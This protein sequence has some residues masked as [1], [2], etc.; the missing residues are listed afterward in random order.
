[1]PHWFIRKPDPIPD[2]ARGLFEAYPM[3]NGQ[4]EIDLKSTEFGRRL[5]T[6][7]P[8]ENARWVM[9][10]LEFLLGVEGRGKG[11]QLR[12]DSD[13]GPKWHQI[14]AL[15]KAISSLLRRKLPFSG[16]DLTI[17][18]FWVTERHWD[19][20][21]SAVIKAVERFAEA[22]TLP[23]ALTTEL[24][25]L[26]DTL[27]PDRKLQERVLRLLGHGPPLPI[28]RGDVWADAALDYL[29]AQDRG[30][31]A[32]W[33]DL[34]LH[35][36][37]ANAGKPSKRWQKQADGL[38]EGIGRGL[39]ST[40]LREWLPL[41]DVPRQL[42]PDEK[43]SSYLPDSHLS[44]LEAQGADVLKGLI[45]CTA[46]WDDSDITRT[47]SSAAISAYKKIPGI[48]PRA[49]KVG[50]A[51]VW[52]LGQMPGEAPLGALAVLKLRIKL[53]SVQN[54]I[55][56]ALDGAAE[57][58]GIQR[59]D[60]E[61][62]IVPV[63]GLQEVGLRREPMGDFVAELTVVSS[64]RTELRWR[65]LDGTLQKSIPKAVK[66]AHGD[67]LKELKQTAKDIEKML[68]AQGARIDGLFLTQKRWTYGVWRQRYLDHPLV[69]T[70]ARRLIWW[71]G[72]TDHRESVCWQD[73]ALCDRQ[74]QPVAIPDEDTECIAL[75]HPIEDSVDAV[76]S[77]RR[78]LS[79]L[80]I[81]QPFK[82]AHREIYLLTDAEKTTGVYSNRFASHILKQHSFNA[83]CGA[84]GWKN[85]LRL[86]V[87]ADYNPARRHLPVWDLR[88]EFW[89]DG[90]RGAS[91]HDINDV[92][93]YLYLT[94]DQVR[95]YPLG[96]AGNKAHAMGG[97]YS[98]EGSDRPENHPLPLTEIPPLVLS[99]VLRDV[100]LF[101]GVSSVGNDPSWND[102]G[103]VARYRDYWDSYSFGELSASASTRR[104]VLQDLIPRL[105]IAERCQL[106][107]RFLVVQ[108]DL[109]TYKIH[110]GS[111]NIL[112]EPTDQ[113][114]CIVP[115]GSQSKVGSGLFLPF[116][117]DQRL[118]VILSKALMLAA[119]RKITD[120]TILS[121][122]QS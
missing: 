9:Q 22:E 82:Q 37:A 36:A 55:S 114:L 3:V 72:S 53:S 68:P 13:L 32:R 41:I 107:D 108:G 97:I 38:V 18:V 87:D 39:L 77:W 33:S 66:E 92:G 109:R 25:H 59:H 91:G 2:A 14:E 75:W 83:L 27:S 10:A 64:H 69:G 93:T 26:V 34:L 118:S 1:M 44:M 78:H 21:V 48:G 15:R 45:W 29:E 95:F 47:I 119:D 111:S 80:E 110:L 113:Y 65:K 19:H 84:R 81:Q 98:S 51:C 67:R 40:R 56:K 90:A 20:P 101:V 89:I 17:L 7:Q 79:S 35:C 99:E 96:A 73:G 42:R 94:T 54:S 16:L 112:M 70:L 4:T 58:Q 88:A 43:P 31:V 106:S 115:S 11:E 49:S 62:L 57:R 120:R 28:S 23:K 71:L 122:I 30:T 8:P 102:G 74:G 5:L 100:D 63:Y 104:E 86:E 76:L 12:V 85:Q 60:L 52:A 116:E 61:E 6:S 50:N 103:Q 24:T 46:V 121:Q 105:A 117:G